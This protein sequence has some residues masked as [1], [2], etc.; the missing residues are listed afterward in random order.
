MSN[1]TDVDLFESVLQFLLEFSKSE[2]DTKNIFLDESITAREKCD[3]YNPHFSLI[4][5]E[6][7]SSFDKFEFVKGFLDKSFLRSISEFILSQDINNSGINCKN[8]SLKFY[9]V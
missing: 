3:S 5:L 2:I 8:L 4:W 6:D 1:A 9:D 7:L